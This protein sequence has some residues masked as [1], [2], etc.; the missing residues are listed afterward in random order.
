[1]IVGGAMLQSVFRNVVFL[2]VYG[3]AVLG[4][5]F[6]LVSWHAR[7]FAYL[8]PACGYVFTISIWKDFISP[9]GVDKDGGWKILHC[10]GCK[11]WMKARIIPKQELE[12]LKR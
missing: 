7:T 12:D 9:H 1:M 5:L 10:P 3:I 4:L 6:L 2:I 8:C 11:H